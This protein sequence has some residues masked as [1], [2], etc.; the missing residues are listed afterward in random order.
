M[1]KNL[2]NKTDR[3]LFSTNNLLSFPSIK[4]QYYFFFLYFLNSKL[5]SPYI[6]FMSKQ[7]KKE[8]LSVKY[9]FQR[10]DQ[11]FRSILFFEVKFC[12]ILMRE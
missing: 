3:N 2:H 6:F 7:S 5:L 11:A 8:F 10:F 4:F 1:V 12:S 9:S